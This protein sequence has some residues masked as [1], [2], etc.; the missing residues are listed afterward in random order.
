MRTTGIPA[1]E[2]ALVE[3]RAKVWRE[4]NQNKKNANSW[5]CP[6]AFGQQSANDK[7]KQNDK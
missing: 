1:P 3:F 5:D 4:L 2:D 6:E 7:M